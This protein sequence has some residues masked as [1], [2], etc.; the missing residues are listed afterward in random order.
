MN[1]GAID[2]AGRRFSG[3]FRWIVGAI[4][5]LS[6]FELYLEIFRFRHVALPAFLGTL[7]ARQ[8]FGSDAHA[9]GWLRTDLACAA[10]SPLVFLA[11][12]FA[13]LGR[14]DA[15]HGRAQSRSEP[16]LSG[17]TAAVLFGLLVAAL[18]SVNQLIWRPA[19]VVDLTLRRG[20]GGFMVLGLVCAGGGVSYLLLRHAGPKPEAP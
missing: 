9:G 11:L 2:F 4:W 18:G 8:H 14:S 16:L 13:P 1:V 12:R 6:W 5:I 15:S 10:L 20:N 3:R 17:A 7:A 19:F